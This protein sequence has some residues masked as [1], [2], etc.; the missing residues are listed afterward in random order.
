MIC[1]ELNFL[2]NVIHTLLWMTRVTNKLFI[3]GN[4]LLKLIVCRNKIHFTLGTC[5]L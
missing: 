2:K 4:Y 5:G 1:Y 3:D